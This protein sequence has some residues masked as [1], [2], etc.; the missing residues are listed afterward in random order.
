M[1]KQ[2]ESQIIGRAGER[3]FQGLIPREWIFQRPEEDIG[4]DGKV[5]IGTNTA[6]GG[7]EFGVQVKASTNWDIKDGVISLA[8]IKTDTLVFWGSRLYPTLLVLYDVSK[9][10]GYYGWASDI[11]NS[12]IE[13]SEMDPNV[14]TANGVD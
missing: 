12:A 13:P 5:T 11:T 9:D 1:V 8:G 6:T 3:W 2:T 7:L 4:L 14:W 10:T